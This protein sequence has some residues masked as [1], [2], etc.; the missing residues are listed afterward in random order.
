M[1]Y[2]SFSLWGSDPIYNVGVLKNVNLV[3]EIY[4]DWQMVVYYDNSVPINTINE[5][6]KRKRTNGRYD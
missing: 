2:V 1:K 6:K 5:L 3:K 4:N